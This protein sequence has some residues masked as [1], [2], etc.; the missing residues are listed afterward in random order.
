MLAAASL[1]SEAEACEAGSDAQAFR[2]TIDYARKILGWERS[3]PSTS[4][5][6]SGD[7]GGAL[8]GT[9]SMHI[10]KH[11][12]GS[13]QSEIR[14]SHFCINCGTTPTSAPNAFCDYC[15][16]SLTSSERRSLKQSDGKVIPRWKEV[17][18]TADQ[19]ADSRQW[20]IDNPGVYTDG[21]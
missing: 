8:M 17:G 4:R 11:R 21:R 15:S 14:P 10:D 16:E 13:Q 19:L 6:V 3:G 7:Q 18:V 9:K 2:K 1:L 20:L 12:K 5:R